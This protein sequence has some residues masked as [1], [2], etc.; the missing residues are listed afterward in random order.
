MK[1]QEGQLDKYPIYFNCPVCLTRNS[2]EIKRLPDRWDIKIDNVNIIEDYNFKPEFLIILSGEFPATKMLLHEDSQEF[3]LF[4]SISPFLKHRPSDLDTFTRLQNIIPA[5]VEND[6]RIIERITNLF[7]NN[8]EEFI[9][10]EI[11]KL[12][13]SPY[14]NIQE[15]ELPRSVRDLVATIPRSFN[16]F[17]NIYNMS[18]EDIFK[19]ISIQR[20]KNESN[21][22]SFINS[23]TEDDIS[24]ILKRA[25]EIINNF[26]KNYR[27]FLP[28]IYLEGNSEDLDAIKE[29]EGLT[30]VSIDELD[31]FYLFAYE[32][33]MEC[34]ELLLIIDNYVNKGSHEI[35]PKMKF[36]KFPP[37]NNLSDY[38][39]L[40][41]GN[42]L[43]VLA[44]KDNTI[45]TII[46]MNLEANLRNAIGHNN[47][48]YEQNSQKIAYKGSEIYLI[49]FANICYQLLKIATYIWDVGFEFM[50][51]KVHNDNISPII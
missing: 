20:T 2:G 32:S 1:F 17:N 40:T 3:N 4:T 23:F 14:F 13:V 7:F 33:I 36:N 24:Q 50:N 19:T 21:Y 22:I 35:F 41:K 29:F 48:K 26:I 10:Q 51:L 27:F 49:E 38:R 37:L 9:E 11:T 43:K 42:R 15:Y 16:Q 6:W 39:K 8:R 28:V 47:Y 34:S 31:K 25:F 12:R 18:V 46:S 5:I 30:T 45:S 44:H